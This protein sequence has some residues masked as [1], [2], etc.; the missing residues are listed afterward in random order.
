M[1]EDIIEDEAG[2]EEKYFSAYFGKKEE[3][4]LLKEKFFSETGSKF[5]WNW[6]AFFSCIIGPIWLA[7]RKMWVFVGIYWILNIIFLLTATTIKNYENTVISYADLMISTVLMIVVS[8]FGNFF[9]IKQME[10]DIFEIKNTFNE[11]QWMQAISAKG[12][13]S[14]IAVIIVVILDLIVGGIIIW[15]RGG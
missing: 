9:Y 2:S 10:R 4:Y 1:A 6:A 15:I 13:V 12:G 3:Y 11:E 5:A 14:I 8:I 7:Y